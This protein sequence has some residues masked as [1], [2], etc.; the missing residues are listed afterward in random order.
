MPDVTLTNVLLSGIPS[1][2]VALVGVVGVVYTQRRADAR[3][4]RIAAANREFERQSWVLD[5]RRELAADCVTAVWLLGAMGRDVIP[6]G[7]DFS[8]LTQDETAGVTRT[9]SALRI[10]LDPAGRAAAQAVLDA[11]LAHVGTF[12]Q[13][14]WDAI[15]DAEDQLIAVINREPPP[16][17]GVFG[18]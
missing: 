11:L 8:D 5:K 6:D 13:Q 14:T 4:D 12:T 10:A 18:P 1:L 15:G 16:V 17:K 9:L 3:Q 7:A 2:L